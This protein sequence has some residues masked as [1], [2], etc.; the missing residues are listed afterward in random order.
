MKPNKS[1]LDIAILTAG[2]VDLFSKC[3]DAI[4]PEMKPEYKITVCNNGSPSSEYEEIYKKLP[5]GSVVKRNNKNEDYSVGCNI[6]MK[7]GNAPLILLVTDDVFLHPDTVS[8]LIKTMDGPSIGI[9]G[10]K[11]LFPED[12]TDKGR[13]A[14]KVQHVGLASNIRGEIIHPLVGWSSNNP[15]CNVSQEVLGVTGACFIIRRN[16]FQRIG[17]FNPIYGK[18]YYEDL[19][20]CLQARELGA[21]IWVNTEAT[22]THGVGQTFQKEG[23][24]PIRENQMIFMGRWGSKLSWSEFNHW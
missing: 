20:L 2:R 23:N 15:K 18:G 7:A 17:G 9:C 24:S 4:L 5:L 8:K 19:E 16:L 3:V 22:A 11:L 6:A 12:S 13:P 10:L 21:K 1:I 14:G